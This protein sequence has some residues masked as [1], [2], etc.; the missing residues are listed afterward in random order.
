MTGLRLTEDARVRIMDDLPQ[1]ITSNG[2]TRKVYACVSMTV[3]R[4]DE[5][6]GYEIA[7]GLITSEGPEVMI[8]DVPADWV[9]DHSRDGGAA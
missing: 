9:I 6:D 4:C 2:E 8:E 1:A 7:L 5:P 3:A